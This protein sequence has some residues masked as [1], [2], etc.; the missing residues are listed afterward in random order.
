MAEIVLAMATSHAPQLSTPVDQ[1]RLHAERDRKAKGLYFRGR[2]Y[3]FE[4]LARQRKGEDLEREITL[5]RM[6]ERYNACQRAITILQETFAAAS[7]NIAV[8]IGDDQDEI[9]SESNMPA[10]SIYWG[11]TVDNAP[12][13][14][15]YVA[16]RSRGLIISDWGTYPPKK[17]TH[18]A[19]PA[20]GKHL[21]EALIS[22]EFDIAHSKSLPAGR[23]MN[24]SI[25]HAYGFV[26]RRLMNDN[27]V[28]NVPVFINTYYPPN[29]PTL[30]RCYEFGEVI[31]RAVKRWDSDKKVA[32]IG[33][34][35][36]SHFVIDEDFDRQGLSALQRR[37]EVGLF[38]IPESLLQSGNS[39]FKNW[40]T[41]AGTIAD[42][43]VEMK[44]VDYVPCYRSDAGTGCAMGF[45][46][47]Q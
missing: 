42:Q 15:E 16:K 13:P 47:W 22:A 24:H 19:Q 27:V 26:Y 18:P 10:F 12:I 32:V 14:A 25:P 20:L 23:F 3:D 9:F 2:K 7:I 36:L 8:I 33:S 21:I 37:D 41:V 30:K 17:L 4:E 29:Q 43:P 34:G 46:I 28:P 5:E 6:T 44:I 39:E 11:E 31:G 1:W 35:G 45:A 38:S 40:I